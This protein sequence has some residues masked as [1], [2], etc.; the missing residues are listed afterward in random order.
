MLNKRDIAEFKKLQ[1]DRYG[2]VL[3]DSEARRR[4][5]L[6]VEHMRLIYQPISVKQFNDF[7]KE[8]IR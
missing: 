6:L 5:S 4:L 7:K 2:V 3:S 1:K 8:K